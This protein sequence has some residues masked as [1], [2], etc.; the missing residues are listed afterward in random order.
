MV[1]KILFLQAP[2]KHQ[3][4]EPE[5]DTKNAQKGEMLDCSTLKALTHQ[6]DCL[7]AI[8]PGLGQVVRCLPGRGTIGSVLLIRANVLNCG[9]HSNISIWFPFF[10]RLIENRCLL[11]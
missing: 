7:S 1:V 2:E 10:E 6:V 3:Q 9:H 4:E 5:I 8:G 11:A